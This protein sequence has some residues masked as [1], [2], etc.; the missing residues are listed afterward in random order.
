MPENQIQII[1]KYLKE[2]NIMLEYGAGGSTLYFAQ[3]VNKYISIE[4]DYEWIEKIKHLENFSKNI[5]LY[6]CQPNNPIK[7]P[8][9]RGSFAD[10]KDYINYIDNLP[11]KKYDI[12][13]I[14]GRARQYCAEKVLNFIDTNSIVFI[15]DFF[16][17]K[18]Y[19]NIKRYYKIIDKYIYG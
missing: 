12:V 16:E 10:F 4:H 8:V 15:H 2:S 5:E 17:R 11:Y 9:W 7:L 1:K 18:R 19:H 3:Y 14:D 13:L 6:Y